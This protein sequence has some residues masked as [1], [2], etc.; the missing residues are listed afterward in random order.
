MSDVRA[1][2]T[3]FF[4]RELCHVI[5][6]DEGKALTSGAQAARSLLSC[7]VILMQKLTQ[8]TGTRSWVVAMVKPDLSFQKGLW[9]GLALLW[10]YRLENH[11][12][13]EAEFN[14]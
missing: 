10:R 11:R 12:M 13:Q 1:F 2:T 3:H 14:G 7:L 6:K 9:K 5:P 8:K 4:G